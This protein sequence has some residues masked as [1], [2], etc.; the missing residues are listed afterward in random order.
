L[1][2]GRLLDAP[3]GAVRI[4]ALWDEVRSQTID[5]G[6][7]EH[8]ADVAVLPVEI[9]WSDVGSW[10]T[11]L[12]V[13]PADATGNV[14]RGLHVAVDTAHT[15]VHSTTGRMIATIGVADLVIVDTEDILLV[16]PANRAQ[17]VRRIVAELK[18]QG[19][20]EYI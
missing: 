14:V 2:I 18:A 6:I 11:L 12:D 15:L 5:Y 4:A 19:K 7:M 8:A 16:C 3:D 17:D 13:L 9:G 10:E 1:A 20:V